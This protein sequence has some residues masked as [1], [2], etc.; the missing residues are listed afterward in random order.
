LRS[1]IIGLR[2]TLVLL[3]VSVGIAGGCAYYNLFYNAEEAFNQAE[4]AGENVPPDERPSDQQKGGYRRCI[5][6]C[7][8]L[9][10]EYPESGYVDDALFYMAK[11]YF[12]LN[13]LREYRTAINNFDAVLSNFPQSQFRAEA[14]YLKALC[15]LSLG[16]EQEALDSLRRLREADPDSR[17]SIEAL[18]QLADRYAD[19]EDYERALNYYERYRE[20]HPKHD[21]RSEV[22]LRHAT[23][24]FDLGRGDEAVLLLESIDPNKMSESTAFRA[25]LLLAETLAELER[26]EEAAALV[27]ELRGDALL[28]KRE[29]ELRHL[30]G[31]IQLSRGLEKEGIETLK[32]IA[33]EFERKDSESRARLALANYYLERYGP[34]DERIQQELAT[35]QENRSSGPSA[36]AARVLASQL[37]NYRELRDR[38]ELSESSPD[39]SAVAPV[40]STAAEGGAREPILPGDPARLSFELAE[41]MLAELDRPEDALFYYRKALTLSPD[42]TSVAP[43]AAYAVGFILQTRLEQPEEAERAF[44]VVRTRFPESPQA[45][46]LAGEEFLTVVARAQTRS[47]GPGGFGPG[48]SAGAPGDFGGDPANHPMRSLRLGG[49]GATYSRRP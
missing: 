40:D 6:K 16:E 45:R 2:S 20:E 12:Y 4:A 24:L 13:E 21:D 25:R 48:S 41:V 28:L 31:E 38:L 19:R 46:A 26:Q 43:R 30:E 37:R 1:N 34:D 23:V 36:Q 11:S 33:E 47:G 14:N 32:A 39:S 3:A 49:P 15:H 29:A 5:E 17:F 7:K 10:E 27:E 42:S 22:A 35:L 9:L 8:L 44:D 18:Y